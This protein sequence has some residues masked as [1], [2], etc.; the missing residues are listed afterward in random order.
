M[1]GIAGL[2]CIDGRARALGAT[3]AAMGAAMRHRGPDD[4][5]Y[6]VAGFDGSAAHAHTGPDSVGE[7]F[8]T[9]LAFAA[10]GHIEAF[11][12]EAHVFLAHRRLSIRDLSVTGHQPMCTEDGRYWIVYNGEV[13]NSDRIRASL[14]ASGETF[15]GTSDTEVVLR[16]FRRWGAACLDHFNGM[17]AFVVWDD[18]ERTLFCARDRLGIKPFHFAVLDGLFVFASDVKTILASGT[19]PFEPDPEGLYHALSFGIAPRPLTCFSPVRAMESGTWMTVGARGLSPPRRY[20]SQPYGAPQTV[21][22]DAR[23]AERLNALLERSV[24]RRLVAD[25]QVACFMSG[26][27]DSTLIT[28]LAARE[29]PGITAFTLAFEGAPEHELASARATAAM[30]PI[31]HVVRWYRPEEAIKHVVE[32]TLCY[33]EPFSSLSPNYLIAKLVAEHGIKV[34]LNGL[35]GDELFG[36]YAKYRRLR[37]RLPG[38]VGRLGDALLCVLGKNARFAMRPELVPDFYFNTAAIF[39]DT[40]KHA[41]LGPRFSGFSSQHVLSE[42]YLPTEPMPRDNVEVMSHL[43]MCHL[44]GNHHLYRVDQFTMH[45]SIEGR[46]P[47]LD[48]EVVEFAASLPSSHKV[49]PGSL[50]HIVRSVAQRYIH[51]SCLD[52]EKK[53]FSLPMREWIA[54]PLRRFCRESL[55]EL[56]ERALVK[57]EAVDAVA[58]ELEA[59]HFRPAHIWMLVSLEQWLRAFEDIA[60]R[61]PTFHD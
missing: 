52:M 18:H 27:V 31:N 8:S 44:V 48:H 53:G 39:R 40:E 32:M 16:A 54:G 23:A 21:L 1:C 3:V 36:G 41:M 17:F 60:R 20:W 51:R 56:R 12:G 15:F 46:F 9:P 57:A 29:R 14:A 49:R 38:P 45:F 50:K 19:V 11:D 55:A 5:G 26:G 47:F 37:P 30:H 43:D 6:M 61:A 59:E 22:T 25:T 2:L 33:E 13:Y 7:V 28:A 10:D 42:M 58:A 24:R 4:E 35:G 34:V